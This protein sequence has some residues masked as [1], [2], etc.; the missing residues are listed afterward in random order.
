MKPDP[1]SVKLS[2]RINVDPI[3][4]DLRTNNNE[5]DRC[6]FRFSLEN[7]NIFLFLF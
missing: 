4:G 1:R 5:R 3:S 7:L 6:D 2:K